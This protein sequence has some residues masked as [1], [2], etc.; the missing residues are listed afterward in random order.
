MNANFTF[1]DSLK[2]YIIYI[3]RSYQNNISVYLFKFTLFK[4]YITP[5]P[6]DFP[7]VIK[8]TLIFVIID[9]IVVIH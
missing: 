1:L 9:Y 8:Y 4:D 5:N 3:M 7:I 2:N 6:N